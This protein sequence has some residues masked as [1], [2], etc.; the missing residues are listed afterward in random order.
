MPQHLATVAIGLYDVRGHLGE[1]DPDFAER[2]ADYFAYCR[3]NDLSIGTIFSDPMRHRHHTEAHCEPLRVVDKRAD[4][5]VVRGARGVGTQSPYANE[6]LCLASPRPG[7]SPDEVVYFGIPVNAEG[8]HII[9]RE[10]FAPANPE[11]HL[12]S[13][14]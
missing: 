8:L 6:L 4:G 1:A 12:V 10:S 13:A 11:D 2:I 9:C 14:A 3:D 5:I 7:R